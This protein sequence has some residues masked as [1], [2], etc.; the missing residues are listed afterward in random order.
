MLRADQLSA[1]GGGVDRWLLGL[2]LPLVA[3]VIASAYEP[4]EARAT[5]PGRN[6]RIAFSTGSGIASALPNGRRYRV[7]ARD[8]DSRGNCF[9]G[10]AFSPNGRRLAIAGCDKWDIYF[11]RA[12]G[13]RLT[14]HR[15]P[16]IRYLETHPSWS[17]DGRQLVV[18]S[19]NL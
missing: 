4:T 17:P 1:H 2:A 3:A 14:R 16:H 15:I 12:D 8:D 19:C 7:I 11:A 5:M 9:Y 18:G 6:G 13:S 10:P